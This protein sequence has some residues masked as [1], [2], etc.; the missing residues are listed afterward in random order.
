M[1]QTD[2]RNVSER[3]IS[4]CAVLLH[5]QMSHFTHA[6]DGS[7]DT[8]GDILQSFAGNGAELK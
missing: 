6:A 7:P 2:F 3:H 1:V 5:E 8:A 4:G